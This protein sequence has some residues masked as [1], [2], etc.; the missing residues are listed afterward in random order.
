MRRRDL[1]RRG[2]AGL[3]TGGV[4]GLAGCSVLGGN[5][6]S[7]VSGEIVEKPYDALEMTTEEAGVREIS[8]GGSELTAFAVSG[9]ATNTGSERLT[10]TRSGEFAFLLQMRVFDGS[11]AEL[12]DDPTESLLTS[13][14]PGEEAPWR[15]TYSDRADQDQ[16]A[17]Y[18]I[19]VE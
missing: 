5:G 12:T 19:T 6:G 18:E 14:D 15:V 16:V 11:G 7:G 4:A 17:R 10:S 1:L 3:L 13:L 8:S 9:T 2:G